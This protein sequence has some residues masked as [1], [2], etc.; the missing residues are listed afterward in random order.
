[1]HG[2]TLFSWKIFLS[3]PGE[4]DILVRVHS[5]SLNPVDL[6]I[7]SGRYQHMLTTPLTLGRDFAGEVVS[8]G[9]HIEHVHP[10]DAVYGTIPFR[11]GSFAEYVLAK[12]SEVAPKPAGLDFVQAAAVPLA[13]LAAWQALFDVADVH[14][15]ERVLILGSAGGVGSF[16]AQFARKKGAVVIGTASPKDEAFLRQDLGIDQVIAQEEPQLEEVVS[17][18][19]VVLNLAD[20]R[21]SAHA[22]R[23]LKP[24]G[25]FVSSV[26]EPPQEE[27]RQLGIRFSTLYAHPR[28]DLLREIAALIDTGDFVVRLDQ[29]FPLH[30]AQD[31][32]ERKRQ[33]KAHGKIVFQLKG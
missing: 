9:A 23:T 7:A 8:V 27:A 30:Q 19:D 18:V 25:R 17:A 2:V 16:A 24:G 26:G 5:A 29:V 13:A 15:G 6:S 11:G 1:L 21:L 22:Y 20:P 3:Q 31:A 14:V 4:D 12:A 33:K 32:F 10:T 28:A